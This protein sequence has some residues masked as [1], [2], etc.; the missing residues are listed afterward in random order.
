MESAKKVFKPEPAKETRLFKTQNSPAMN[1]HLPQSASTPVGGHLA[2]RTQE[3][4][5]ITQ[6]PWILSTMHGCHINFSRTPLR[7][8]PP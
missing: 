8:T 3:W 7:N 4:H 1:R 5:K 6:D 2:K